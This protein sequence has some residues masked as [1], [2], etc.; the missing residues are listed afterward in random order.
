MIKKTNYSVASKLPLIS[1]IVLNY[2]GK[3]YLKECFSSIYLLNYPN[4]KYEVI[5]VDNGSSDD[6]VAFVKSN[7]PWVIV[8]QLKKNYG[9][10]GG[11]NRSI[12]YARGNYLVFLNNDTM[13]TKDWLSTLVNCA[14][15]HSTPICAS[16]ILFMDNSMVDELDGLK[17]TITGRGYGV[18]SS[19]RKQNVGCLY[20]GY[21]CAASM[22][23]DKNLFLSLGGFDEDYFACLDDTDF[24]WR[25]WLFGYKV[26]YC[27]ESIVYHAKGGTA[28][29]GRMSVLKAFHGTKGAYLNILKNLEI[30]NLIPSIF[31]AISYDFL[32]FAVLLGQKKSQYV[33]NK[34]KSYSWLVKNLPLILEKRKKIQRLRKVSDKWLISAG[35]MASFKDAFNMYLSLKKS[36]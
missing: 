30:K 29:H 23:I 3:R 35:F 21:P 7:F 2:N 26:L 33:K 13:V 25:A 16:K 18:F 12:K 36:C 31:I 17:F 1:I 14:T 15:R 11:N 34:L 4:C 28:G 27:P 6:S 20:I 19:A 32:E 5:M 22:L 24:G 10:G 8:V 9:F